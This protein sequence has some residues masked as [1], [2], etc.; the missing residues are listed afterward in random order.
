MESPCLWDQY[1]FAVADGAGVVGR[2]GQDTLGKG[3]L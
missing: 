2:I 1:L 3:H